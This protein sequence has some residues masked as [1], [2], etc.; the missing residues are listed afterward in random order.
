MS[1]PTVSVVIVS[2]DR[3]DHLALCLKALTFQYRRNFEIVVV[4]NSVSTK[5]IEESGLAD[6]I[7]SAVFEPKNISAARNIGIGMASGEIIAFIDD[8]AIAEPGW[9]AYLTHPFSNNEIVSS[10]GFVVG[11]NGFDLQ[12][13]GETIDAYGTATCLDIKDTTVVAPKN[14]AYPKTHGT[15]CAFRRSTLVEMG[16]F[17]ENYHYFLDETDLNIRI[18]KAGGQ[19]A[20]VPDAEVH[21]AFAVNHQ[22]RQSR[23]P[24]SL[25]EIG[26]SSAYLLKKY[27]LNLDH[28]EQIRRSQ[29]QRLKNFVLTGF[30]EPRD[31][32][33][34]LSSLSNGIDAG[35]QRVTKERRF[36][37]VSVSN[38]LE[39]RPNTRPNAAKFQFCRHIS[40]G[41]ARARAK[42]LAGESYATTL[43]IFSWSS[44]RHQRGFHKD[45]Y[46]TQSGGLFG[47]SNRDQPR[48]RIETLKSRAMAEI[49]SLKA[50]RSP[51]EIPLFPK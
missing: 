36:P 35:L 25:Y 29:A 12:W 5:G 14:D 22:R 13:A 49:S 39:F 8:D 51:P 38:F 31:F 45:G 41:S 6:E 43:L 27:G 19:T 15:N 7:K 11:R 33:P 23:A 40:S 48:F 30:L 18:G 34:L 17:D 21:H 10:G 46:W 28:L 26:A 9:L 47:K 3:P 37:P 50:K 44:W 32:D 24:S 1:Q 16:G 42:H 20:I 2:H 4:H